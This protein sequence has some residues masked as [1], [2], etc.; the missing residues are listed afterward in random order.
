[1]PGET[2]ARA[3]LE[4]LVGQQIVTITGRPNTVLR[5]EEDNVVVATRRAPGGQPVPIGWVEA[6]LT[7]FWTSGRSK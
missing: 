2:D 5:V 3:L 4:S 1:M 6:A 7:G